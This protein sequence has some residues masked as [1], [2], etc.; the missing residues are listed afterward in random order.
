MSANATTRGS[1]HH[2][3]VDLVSSTPKRVLLV[4]AN[5]GGPSGSGPPRPR[6]PTTPQQYS[7]RKVTQAVIEAMG[8]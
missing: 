4:V 3:L 2:V 7:S 6:I 1:E 5:P 8:V